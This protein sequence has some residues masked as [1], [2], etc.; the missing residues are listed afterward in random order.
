VGDQPR[1]HSARSVLAD[2][3]VGGLAA[4]ARGATRLTKDL[5]ICPAWSTENLERTVA[6][7]IEVLLGIPSV[8]R[9]ELARYEELIDRW[10]P[11]ANWRLVGTRSRCRN[12]GNRPQNPGI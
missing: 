11:S 1:P 7:D 2:L 9:F 5:D 4:Q 8:S 6:G 12:P 3:L 10:A